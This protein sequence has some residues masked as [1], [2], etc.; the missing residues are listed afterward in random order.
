MIG[1][2]VLRYPLRALHHHGRRG[3]GG[4]PFLGVDMFVRRPV[5]GLMLVAAVAVTIDRSKSA[6]IK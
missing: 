4:K 3:D 2:V 5:F 1:F 6:V